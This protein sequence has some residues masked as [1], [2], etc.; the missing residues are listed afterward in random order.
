MVLSP[1]LIWEIGVSSFGFEVHLQC[2]EIYTSMN[3]WF[4]YP[5]NH[6]RDLRLSQ[7]MVM[8]LPT[9]LKE[10]CFHQ[11]FYEVH[12]HIQEIYSPTN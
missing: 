11:I 9:D 6:V 3:L 7:I 8:S 2:G 12:L 4:W 5:P 10:L 1:L